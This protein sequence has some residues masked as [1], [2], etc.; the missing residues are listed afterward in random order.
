MFRAG[1][2][3]DGDVPW[4]L[5]SRKWVPQKWFGICRMGKYELGKSEGMVSTQSL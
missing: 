5:V 1:D 4:W 2:F 3:G